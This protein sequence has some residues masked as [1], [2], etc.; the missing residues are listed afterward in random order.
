MGR[1]RKMVYKVK[2]TEKIARLFEGWQETL[3]WSC[4]QNVMGSLYVDST[5]KPGSAMAVS[6][7]FCFFAGKPNE[8]LIRY[9]FKCYQGEHPWGVIMVPQNEEWGKLIETCYGERAKKVTRYAIKKEPDVFDQEKLQDAVNALPAGYILKMI[10]ENLFWSCRE[11]PWC[12]D[13]VSQY[14]NYE[15]YRKYGLGVVVLKDGEPV[16][17][18]SSYTSFLGGIEIEIDTREDHRRKGLAYAC[19]AKLILEC[20][21]RGWYPSWDAQNPW[22]VALAEKLG[23]HFDHEYTAYEVF[24][25]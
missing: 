21:A 14:D 25:M 3:I 17:G 23:Y 4:I 18:A 22:S 9:W 7:D 15:M 6:G 5:E 13:W 16:S 10:D 12:K 19:A 11:I 2:G 20:L 8:E 1:R 24:V